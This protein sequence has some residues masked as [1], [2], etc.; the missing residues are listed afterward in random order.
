MAYRDNPFEKG[1]PWCDI[2]RMAHGAEPLEDL[3]LRAGKERE[4]RKKREPE[5]LEAYPLLEDENF[6]NS[7]PGLVQ[8]VSYLHFSGINQSPEQIRSLLGAE[9]ISNWLSL[10]ATRNSEATEKY[11]L[12]RKAYA[13][14]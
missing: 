10:I 8:V 5:V 7:H 1:K 4:E 6:V 2:L 12:L 9:D 11:K 3:F 13:K 14:D